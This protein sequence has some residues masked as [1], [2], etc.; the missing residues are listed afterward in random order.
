MFLDKLFNR[1]TINLSK[2]AY[3]DLFSGYYSRYGI[4]GTTGGM[5]LVNLYINFGYCLG[6]LIFSIIV[7]FVG[8]I[9]SVLRYLIR[10]EFHTACTVSLYAFLS[11]HF[12]LALVAN[13]THAF[14]LP[15]IFSGGIIAVLLLYLFLIFPLK[16]KIKQR[17]HNISLYI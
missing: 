11:I 3:R 1:E 13:I 6:V 12:S 15:F 14:E 4:T 7:S 16:T 10:I 17:S 8:I 2:I 5:N 9:D